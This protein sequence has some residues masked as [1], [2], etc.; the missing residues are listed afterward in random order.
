MPL[1]RVAMP[2]VETSEVTWSFSTMRPFT[3]P[4]RVLTRI[5]RMIAA[6]VENPSFVVSPASMMFASEMLAATDRSISPVSSGIM[7]ASEPMITGA[8][9]SRVNR[10]LS[11]FANSSGRARLNMTTVRTRKISSP[12][13]PIVSV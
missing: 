2:R 10:T 13:L 4:T 11:Q 3:S 9:W 6:G 7:T 5:A 12:Y 1:S 8:C